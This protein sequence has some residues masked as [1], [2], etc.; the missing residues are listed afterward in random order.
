MRFTELSIKGVFLI[1]REDRADERGFFARTYCREEFGRHGIDFEI[2][3]ANMSFNHNRGTLR[4]LHYQRPPHREIKLVS[5]VRGAIFDCVVDLRKDSPT[6]LRHVGVELREFGPMLYVPMDFAHGYQTLADA[7]VVHYQVSAFYA[8]GVEAGLRWNDPVLA[9]DWPD[10]G[11]R[12]ISEK[13]RAHP[14]LEAMP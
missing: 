7:T 6:Y 14:L 8:P 9:I 5:C 12:I 2:K 11:E 4:G 10:C 13:D 1:E 3:Q